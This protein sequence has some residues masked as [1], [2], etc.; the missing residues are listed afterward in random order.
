MENIQKLLCEMQVDFICSSKKKRSKWPHFSKPF[1][2]LR[3][4]TKGVLGPDYKSRAA[5]VGRD[6]FQ[7]G[8]T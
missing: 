6:D 2:C 3:S 8:F 1:K 4:L 5:S 7:A